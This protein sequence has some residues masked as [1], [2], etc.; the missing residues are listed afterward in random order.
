[1]KNKVGRPKLGTQDAK[2]IVIAA[3][4]TLPEVKAI[5]AAIATSRSSKSEWLRKAVLS[6]VESGKSSP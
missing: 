2:G 4:F 5:R 1:M 3:R 6:A